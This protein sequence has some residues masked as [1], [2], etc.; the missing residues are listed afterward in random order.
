MWNAVARNLADDPSYGVDLGDSALLFGMLNLAGADSAIT[1]WSDKY[2]WDFWRPWQAIHEAA[3]D[4]NPATEP[5]ASWTALLVAPYP[6]HP[7]GHLGLDG[8]M[9][10]VLPMF[11]G[12]DKVEFSVVSNRFPNETRSFDRFSEPLK[13][14]IDA[15]IWAGLHYRTADVQSSVIGKKVVH[16]ME[17]NYF[18]PLR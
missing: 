9:L 16:Y 1:V 3:S 2:Y 7:S 8:S 11:F 15:R 6:E 10:R 18:Q 13:E 14:I 17:H 12:T 4:G 5:D